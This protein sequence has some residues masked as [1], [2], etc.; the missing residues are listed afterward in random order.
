L[1]QLAGVRQALKVWPS[2]VMYFFV[3]A[4]FFTCL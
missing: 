3:P 1:V 4:L 2:Y